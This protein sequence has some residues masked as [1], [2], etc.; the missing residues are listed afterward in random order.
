M[1][2]LQLTLVIMFFTITSSFASQETKIANISLNLKVGQTKRLE[3]KSNPT[4]GFA[5]YPSKE[6]SRKRP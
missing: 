6:I 2:L 4:T 5:W 3:L 1:K